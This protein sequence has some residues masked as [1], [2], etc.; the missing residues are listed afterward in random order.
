M[1]FAILNKK[2]LKTA[3]ILRPKNVYRAVYSLLVD[4]EADITTGLA[5][6]NKDGAMNEGLNQKDYNLTFLFVIYMQ[7]E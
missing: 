1:K 6:W 5:Y 4:G 7:N 2:P 3:P